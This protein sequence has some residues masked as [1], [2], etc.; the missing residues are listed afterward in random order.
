[1]SKTKASALTLV[2]ACSGLLAACAGDAP[3]TPPP[4]NNAAAP[5]TNTAK[6]ADPKPVEMKVAGMPADTQP[7]FAA[8]CATCHGP[9]A[10]G[11]PPAPN[12]L[13]VKDKHPADVWEKYLEDPKSLEKDSKMP[14]IP[15]TPEERKKLAEW[16]AVT[17]G[18]GAAQSAE[19]PAEK[20]V[21][22]KK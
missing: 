9:D 19:K 13:Q 6:P 20:P 5:V 8:K 11:K 3:K 10:T 16:L 18:G 1:L 2:F 15:L 12:I 22:T 17:T 14:K 4:A 7:I 21:E